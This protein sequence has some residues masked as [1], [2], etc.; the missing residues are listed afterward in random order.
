LKNSKEEYPYIPYGKQDISREDVDAIIEQLQSI[1]ITQGPKIQEFENGVSSYVGGKYGVA[2]SSCTGALHLACIALGLESGDRLWTVPNTFV[3]SSNCA[4]YCGAEV[5]FVDIDPISYC[6]DVDALAE[7]LER[8]KRSNTLPKIVVPVHFAGQSCDMKRIHELGQQYGFKII[9]DAA[10]AIGGTYDGNPVG[11]CRYS[12]ITVFSF[13]PVKILTTGEG[14][15]LVTQ[16]DVIAERLMH[17]RTHG[18]VRDDACLEQGAWYYEMREL[19]YHYRITDIQA[20]LGV[21]Q[22]ARVDSFL[23]KRRELVATYNEKLEQLPLILPTVKSGVESAWHLY[24][25]QN[26]SDKITRRELFDAMRARGIIVNVHYIPVYWQPVYQKL[27]F[28]KGYC[29]VAEEYYA[30]A[31][32]IPLFYGL[33]EEE[34]ERVVQSL[35]E[36]LS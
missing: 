27:G 4:L 17:L 25:I 26:Q 21:S 18:I 10:H 2:V 24:V 30:N 15:M 9:E 8:A 6:M 31:M 5:D 33:L 32:S 34:Q 20:A 14:G 7:K 3:A 35:H 28:Q 11:S 16:S 13:H 19:G 29:P 23:E 12:D 1:W 36:L 22:L